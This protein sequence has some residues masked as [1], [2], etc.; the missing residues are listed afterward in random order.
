MLSVH[1]PAKEPL[2]AILTAPDVIP[3][4]PPLTCAVKVTV[5]PYMLGLDDELSVVVDG[6]NAKAVV[7]TIR[8]ISRQ[9]KI[10]LSMVIF[11]SYR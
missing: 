7:L 9:L 10:L 11:S 3:A 5:D 4:P 6:V 2:I 1:P 8:H